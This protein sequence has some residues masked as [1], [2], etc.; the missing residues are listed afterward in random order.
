MKKEK[1][2]IP[3]NVYEK[4]TNDKHL[5]ILELKRRANLINDRIR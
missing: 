4:R 5:E 3:F 1:E 2:L